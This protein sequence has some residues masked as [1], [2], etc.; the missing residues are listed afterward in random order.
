MRFMSTVSKSEWL[1]RILSSRKRCLVTNTQ[2]VRY[3]FATLRLS[4]S[5]DANWNLLGKSLA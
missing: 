3:K 2:I 4:V 1:R 5:T